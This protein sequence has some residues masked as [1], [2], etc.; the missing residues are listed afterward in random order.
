[1]GKEIDVK[2]Q[3]NGTRVVQVPQK[4][5]KVNTIGLGGV[6]VCTPGTG[7]TKITILRYSSITE[8]N[9]V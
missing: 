6:C 7:Y 9:S 8:Y 3:I 1:V 2:Y 4:T 5:N